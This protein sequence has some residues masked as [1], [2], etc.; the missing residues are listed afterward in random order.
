M[1]YAITTEW[2]QQ[3]TVRGQTRTALLSKETEE[4]EWPDDVAGA[5]ASFLEEH[6]RVSFS[7]TEDFG[8]GGCMTDPLTL[9]CRAYGDCR[10]HHIESVKGWT[11]S[12]VDELKAGESTDFVTGGRKWA[13]ITVTALPDAEPDADDAAQ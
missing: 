11:A 7:G 12:R 2:H 8:Q 3:R 13:A 4:V 9:R 1:R 6:P 10:A 5:V